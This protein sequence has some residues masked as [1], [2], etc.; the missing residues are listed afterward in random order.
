MT[1]GKEGAA[2]L[3][4]RGNQEDG[5]ADQHHEQVEA[6]PHQVQVLE[7][8]SG[9]AMEVYKGAAEGQEHGNE[10]CEE[11][12]LEF[13]LD[14]EGTQ[15]AS[16]LLAIASFFSR[17]SFSLNYLFSDMLKAWNMKQLAAVDKIGDCWN[18][19]SALLPINRW[20]FYRS[21]VGDEHLQEDHEAMELE[22]WFALRTT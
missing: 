13:D 17:K 5:G 9:W 11:G 8:A 18:R 12:I 20:L 4:G 6:C 19:P 15:E 16:R 10:D 7:E 1:E 22:S 14:E 2:P 3:A 21:T